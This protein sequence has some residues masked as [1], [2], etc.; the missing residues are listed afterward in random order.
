MGMLKVPAYKLMSKIQPVVTRYVWFDGT[1]IV[2]ITTLLK[3]VLPGTLFLF[4]LVSLHGDK[5]NCRYS[6]TVGFFF[7][8][9]SIISLIADG[10]HRYQ[11]DC[12]H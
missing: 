5:C 11:H 12:G 3:Y 2:F 10:P 4:C 9:F 7:F 1:N 6:I 8:F